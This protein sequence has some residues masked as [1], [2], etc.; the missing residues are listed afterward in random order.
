MKGKKVNKKGSQ[1]PFEK[2]LSAM[3][4]VLGTAHTY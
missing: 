4:A 1:E 3:G 2:Q